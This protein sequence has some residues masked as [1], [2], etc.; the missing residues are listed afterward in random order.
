MRTRE[1]G[2]VVGIALLLTGCARGTS[3]DTTDADPEGAVADDVLFEQVADLPGV[4]ATEDLRFQQDFGLPPQYAGRITAADD[5]DP[6][7]VLDEA[8]SI[9]HQGRAGVGL[10]VLVTTSEKQTYGLSSLVGRDGSAEDRYGPQP[11]EPQPT[12]TVR[13]C[14]PPDAGSS[15]GGATPTP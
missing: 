11:T 2:V 8:L 10:E 5:A 4:A 1:L 13:P 7:C 3:D 15:L 9:L 6:L 14:T 12:A